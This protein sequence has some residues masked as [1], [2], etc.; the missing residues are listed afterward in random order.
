MTDLQEW[1][2]PKEEVSLATMEKALEDYTLARTEYEAAKA[3]SNGKHAIMVEKEESILDLLDKTG[4]DSWDGKAGK[5]SKTTRMEY[6]TIKDPTEK[7]AFAKWL[8]TKYGK[9]MF[10]SLFGVNSMTFN[11]FCRKEFDNGETTIPGVN[12]PTEKIGLSFRK[13]K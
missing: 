4:R 7:I 3:V 9:D 8:E 12:E 10:W 11:S 2:T 1:N 5:I 13:K 6:T